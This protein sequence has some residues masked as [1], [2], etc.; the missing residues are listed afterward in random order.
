MCMRTCPWAE[1]R[2]QSSPF[3]LLANLWPIWCCQG[4]GLKVGPREAQGSLPS[5]PADLGRG[6][7]GCLLEEAPRTSPQVSLR[8]R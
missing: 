1:L 2:S 7:Q 4:W 5:S 8:G 3:L 6:V